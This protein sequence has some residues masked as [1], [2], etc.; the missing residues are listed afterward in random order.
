MKINKKSKIIIS[1]ALG[2]VMFTT[3]AIAQVISKSGYDQL[4]DSVKYTAESCSTNLSSYTIDTLFVIKDNGTVIT[5]QGSLDKVD[6]SNQTKE[7][8]TTS[9]EG[10]VKKD[11]YFYSDKSGYI[12]RNSDQD[13]YYATEYTSPREIVAP[14]NPFKEK[15]ASDM[16][17]IADAIVGS[18]KDA[19]VVTESS[20]GSKTLSGSLSESQIPALINAVVSLQSK[21]EFSNGY[22]NQNPMPKITK[23]VFV[24]EIKGNM[25]TTKEGLIQSVLGSGVIVGT[26][27][28]DKEHNLSFEVL[29]KITNVNLTKVNKPDLSGKKV[30]KNVERDYSKLSNPEKYIGKYKTDM[31][32][33][34]DGKFEK[35]GESILDITAMDSNGVSGRYYEEY[36]AGYEEYAKNKK[37]FKFDTKFEK[38]QFN[39]QF[40]VSSDSKNTIKGNI[41]IDQGS[42]NIYFNIDSSRSSNII[43]DCQYSKVFN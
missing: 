11:G 3:T 23:D 26:D 12:T 21:T 2:S 19:V 28:N 16:E 33:E 14:T 8:I 27:E 17:K 18:L 20:D 31:I 29:A 6:V 9:I 40:S 4:K 1:L 24:K 36:A 32:L 37:D 15:G 34:K 39:G 30:E 38:D 10:G 42:P 41:S 43:F 7:N 35:V 13:I 25:V 5:S 22:N